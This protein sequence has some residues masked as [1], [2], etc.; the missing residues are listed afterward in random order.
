MECYGNPFYPLFTKE[1]K[2]LCFSENKTFHFQYKVA[3]KIYKFARSLALMKDSFREI[4]GV[5]E[6]KIIL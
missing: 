1:S 3:V 6:L 4:I 5:V 2:D